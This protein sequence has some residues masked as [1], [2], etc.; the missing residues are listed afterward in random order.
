[1]LKNY[2]TTL[3]NEILMGIISTG[4]KKYY[5][6]DSEKVKQLEF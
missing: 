1:M 2:Y 3:E 4:I 5:I 6:K